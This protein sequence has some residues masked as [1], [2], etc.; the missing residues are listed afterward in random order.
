L[1]S[2]GFCGIVSKC[3]LVFAR[4]ISRLKTRI[5]PARA[6]KET[7]MPRY[8]KL[9][10]LLAFCAIAYHFIAPHLHR[11]AAESRAA[12]N[13]VRPAT[14]QNVVWSLMDKNAPAHYINYGVA[15]GG[16]ETACGKHMSGMG[17]TTRFSDIEQMEA[18]K[19]K[20]CEDCIRALRR[21]TGDAPGTTRVHTR[22]FKPK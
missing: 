21:F 18:E 6:E 3:S 12:A 10:I 9:S 16:Y 2:G 5:H 15:D 20:P 14:Q 7:E 19:R 13:S 8:V 1:T 17:S 11:F 22:N 4:E